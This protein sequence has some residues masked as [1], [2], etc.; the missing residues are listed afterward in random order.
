[1]TPS[2]PT[3]ARLHKLLSYDAETGVFVWLSGKRAGRVAG[4]KAK[5]GYTIIR[6]DGQNLYAHRLAWVHATG[7]W[8]DAFIDHRDGVRWNN[9]LSNL[10]PATSIEN[11]QNRPA[12]RNNKSGLL[13]VSTLGGKYVAQIQVAGRH[14]LLGVR[15]DPI[16]AHNLYLAAKARLHPFQPEMRANG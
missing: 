6:V 16:E 9:A 15:K 3:Q 10:R 8:P 11:A 1:M 2:L 13:G 12:N 14:F 4:C 5:D 7:S